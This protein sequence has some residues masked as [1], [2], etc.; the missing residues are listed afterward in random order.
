VTMYVAA[1]QNNIVAR[2]ATQMDCNTLCLV[3]LVTMYVATQ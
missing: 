3:A 1:Q 2:G